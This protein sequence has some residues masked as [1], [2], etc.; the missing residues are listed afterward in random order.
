MT[1]KFGMGIDVCAAQVV[2]NLGLPQ[3]AEDDVQ[4]KGRV[5]R[6]KNIDACGITY[7]KKKLASAALLEAKANL[8][9]SQASQWISDVG[10]ASR[11]GSID[12]PGMQMAMELCSSCLILS[13]F[14]L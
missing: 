2:I 10:A 14:M 6:D 5:G 8:S 3:T 12:A 9:I 11:K 4:Q 1:I 13:A 7:V